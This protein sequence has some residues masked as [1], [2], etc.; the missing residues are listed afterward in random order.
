MKDST[1]V[2][3]IL[4][5]DESDF[6]Q[7]L[8]NL[9]NLYS[10][11]GIFQ[12]NIVGEADSC[13]R[14]L[15]LLNK[16]Q[17]KLMLL[18]LE[19]RQENGINFLKSLQ[20]QNYNTKVLVLSSHQEEE[21]IFQAMYAGAQGYIF[22]PNLV[23]HIIEAINTVINSEI[24]LP[25][26]VATGFFSQFNKYSAHFELDSYSIP[27]AKFTNRE[28]EV[29]LYLVQGFSNEEIAQKLFI[30]IATVK[31]HLTSIFNKL[32]VKSRTQAIV[33][34]LKQNLIAC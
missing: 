21:L 26:E 27:K 14:A 1:K 6:R 17:P 23:M 19:L 31:A 33:I 22:K 12:L 8:K 18:D 28:Q 34:A 30:T 10:Q 32:G 2:S 4:V 11:S 29:L 13:A 9:L 16:Y 3:L 25:P 7:S 15:V 20:K 24:Y 5:D